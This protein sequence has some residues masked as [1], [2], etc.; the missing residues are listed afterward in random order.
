V[1]QTPL[2]RVG[3]SPMTFIVLHSCGAR[4][5]Y[6]STGD[7]KLDARLMTEYPLIPCM[8]CLVLA[9]AT[10]GEVFHTKYVQLNAASD[11]H[12]LVPV[13]PWPVD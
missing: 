9:A 7:D 2:Q 10:R 1:A 8:H 5:V 11:G 3:S 13:D 4:G 12:G 6:A